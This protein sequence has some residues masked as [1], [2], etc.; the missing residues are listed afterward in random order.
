[1]FFQKKEVKNSILK[2]FN[3]SQE[4]ANGAEISKTSKG[5]S[6]WKSSLQNASQEKYVDV[7][8]IYLA[9]EP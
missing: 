2:K 8:N 1:M 7:S 5:T 6:K 4:N 3:L 9:R